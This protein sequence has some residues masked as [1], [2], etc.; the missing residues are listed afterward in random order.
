MKKKLLVLGLL[1]MALVSNAQNNDDQILPA[2]LRSSAKANTSSSESDE[3]M[4]FFAGGHLNYNLNRSLSL[5]PYAGVW[6]TD[7]LRF[8]I[9]PRY[10]LTWNYYSNT[11]AHSFG[12][13]AFMQAVI[14]QYL[15]LHVGYEYLSYPSYVE[16]PSGQYEFEG[17]CNVHSVAA[18]IGFQTQISPTVSM[19][20]MYLIYP[21]SSENTLYTVNRFL[22]MFVR[23]G[24]EVDLFVPKN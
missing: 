23:F 24:I 18:G 17:R 1:L 20:G 11:A 15:I 22:S 9:G 2:S 7:W 10:E 4:N 5:T 16:L 12:A 6:A 13:T 3:G 19:N 21:Y 14:A 8:G